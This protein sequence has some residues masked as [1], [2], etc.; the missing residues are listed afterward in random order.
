M[1]E[2][3]NARK[4]KRATEVSFAVNSL[5]A[6]F[7]LVSGILGKSGAMV[8]DAIHTFSDLFTDVIVW[9]SIHIFQKP[10]DEEHNYGHGKIE[11]VASLIVSIA[12]FLAGFNIL[13][14]GVTDIWRWADGEVFEGIGWIALVAAIFSIVLKEGLF[15]YQKKVG[16]TTGNAAVTAN[17]WHNRSD[18]LSSVGTLL[19][20][21]GAVLLGPGFVFLDFLA[22]IF[23]SFFIFRVAWKILGTNINQLM[24]V[25]LEEQYLV[26]IREIVEG[27]E[28]V[29][30]YHKLRTRK[31]G[32]TFVIDIHILVD[33][34]LTVKKSHGI[35]EDIEK[36]ISGLLG[37][38]T[39]I[40]IHIEP[41]G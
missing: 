21:G 25:S 20:V 17:A 2:G 5:L 16:M 15:R 14:S 3:M 31:T 1:P 12:L 40:N 39:V 23:V 32:K 4:A 36:E 28:H 22:Q 7:K 6:V 26:K 27:H 13:K 34:D 41:Y 11:N 33:K 18:A 10:A 24:D 38:W 29:L 9:I 30:D 35:S 8:A 37:R 19:G